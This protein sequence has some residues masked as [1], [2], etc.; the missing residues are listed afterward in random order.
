MIL[1]VE[2]EAIIRMIAADMLQDAGFATLE[3]SGPEDA[4]AQFAR[5][6]EISVLFTDINMPG[7]FDGVE[8]ARRVHSFRPDVRLILTSGRD[9]PQQCD[10]PEDGQ[11]LPKPYDRASLARLVAR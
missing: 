6:P 8:L 3:A 5:H 9:A 10:L 4:L 11:F 7:D 2:D 1:V